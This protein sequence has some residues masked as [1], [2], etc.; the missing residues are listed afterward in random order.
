MIN[1]V[2]HITDVTDQQRVQ[3][4]ADFEAGLRPD[5]PT[6]M[7]STYKGLEYDM[8]VR[9]EALR[10]QEFGLSQA[11]YAL[12]VKRDTLSASEHFMAAGVDPMQ[13][14]QLA[15][16]YLK[17]GPLPANL[18]MTKF[19]DQQEQL[20]QLQVDKLNLEITNLRANDPEINSMFKV[21]EQSP[22]KDRT[23]S[24]LLTQ[25]KQLMV[26]KGI[27]H[28]MPASDPGWVDMFTNYFKAVGTKLVTGKGTAPAGTATA[29]GP[30]RPIAP[31]AVAPP[32]KGKVSPE[33]AG[34]AGTT[35]ELAKSE[36]MQTDASTRGKLSAAMKAAAAA[37]D[38]ND[39]AALAKAIT[40]LQEIIR[41]SA[42]GR[43]V[44]GYGG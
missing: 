19:K 5:R 41:V 7:P 44:K 27:V 15:D 25:I 20:R 33:Q 30:S 36:Y 9:G 40:D 24:P 35:I 37:Q 16:S 43:G 21:L 38:N 1:N 32:P 3:A 42:V 28:A 6:Q 26:Q 31:T 8:S 23:G 13:A 14:L 4:M 22:E 2:Y 17:G 18:D 34:W 39:G 11:Q 10:R 29:S 12:G